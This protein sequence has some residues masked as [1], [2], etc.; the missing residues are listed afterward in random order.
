VS[1]PLLLVPLLHPERA[2]ERRSPSVSSIRSLGWPAAL[3]ATLLVLLT[4]PAWP[5]VFQGLA[6][7]AL[8]GTLLF[9]S[10]LLRAVWCA[11]ALADKEAT[12]S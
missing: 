8:A 9:A 11:W 3:G 7:V 12:R 1:L 6:I 2:R 10:C 4:H 5:G